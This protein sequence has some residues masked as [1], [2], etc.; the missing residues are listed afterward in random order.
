MHRLPMARE[1]SFNLKS[2]I[3]SLTQLVSM[4]DVPELDLYLKSVY[5]AYNSNSEIYRDIL[6]EELKSWIS[7]F[8]ANQGMIQR[9]KATVEKPEFGFTFEIG[10]ANS[11]YGAREIRGMFDPY[12]LLPAPF[13]KIYPRLLYAH[14]F[15][16]ESPDFDA[17]EYFFRYYPKMTVRIYIKQDEQ[18]KWILHPSQHWVI[19]A[20][21]QIEKRHVISYNVAVAVD[22]RTIVEEELH[23]QIPNLHKTVTVEDVVKNIEERKPDL[24]K[25]IE[26]N[27]NRILSTEEKKFM[28]LGDTLRVEHASELRILEDF[29]TKFEEEVICKTPINLPP[30]PTTVLKTNQNFTKD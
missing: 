21:G 14:N 18:G 1:V 11:M 19:G 4:I 28:D 30:D 9:F 29:V 25:E 5:Y 10:R 8:G 12:L 22:L 24:K 23:A 20:H 26:A 27:L 15:I 16:K 3:N 17:H 13:L 7:F 6:S 2:L